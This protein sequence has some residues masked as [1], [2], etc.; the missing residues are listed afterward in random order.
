MEE[1][2]KVYSTLTYF[3]LILLTQ[4]FPQH[5]ER[6]KQNP[7][8][9][10]PQFPLRQRKYS[11]GSLKGN[12]V[13]LTTKCCYNSCYRLK[14]ITFSHL[15]GRL[16]VKFICMQK[17]W[18]LAQ[19]IL[20]PQWGSKF[21]CSS[22]NKE[23]ASIPTACVFLLFNFL[24]C[25]IT[26]HIVISIYSC[27]SFDFCVFDFQQTIDCNRV[28]LSELEFASDFCLKITKTTEC[29]VSTHTTHS[30]TET[31]RVSTVQT[32]VKLR[33]FKFES[34]NYLLFQIKFVLRL[35]ACSAIFYVAEI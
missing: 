7:S 33:K 17:R 19:Q 35:M 27:A 26:V 30:H 18:E 21:K 2:T 1:E 32:F 8:C 15:N 4:G 13:M 12:T 29:T 11:C 24:Y 22:Q 20:S 9:N 6:R 16:I 14:K 25:L 3:N 28:C 31:S 5:W 23:I 10:K 34:Q